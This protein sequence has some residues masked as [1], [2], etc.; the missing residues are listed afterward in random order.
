R[1]SSAWVGCGS[2]AG[3]GKWQTAS[4]GEGARPGQGMIRAYPPTDSRLE[5][6]MNDDKPEWLSACPQE[7]RFLAVA[8]RQAGG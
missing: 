3:S 1:G 2:L 7:L 8:Q 6:I 5:H 4:Y